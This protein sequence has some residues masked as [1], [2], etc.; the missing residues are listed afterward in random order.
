MTITLEVPSELEG[1]LQRAARVQ[2][3]DI[4]TYLL[5]SA[6]HQLRPDVLSEAESILFLRLQSLFPPEQSQEYRSLC[7]QS[8]SD[9]ISQ[10]DR[11]RLLS[12]IEQRDIKNAERLEI[13]AELA[14]LRAVPVHEMMAQLGIRPD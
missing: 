4:E 14:K 3:V 13:V 6:R 8:D 11:E 7:H 5:N 2:G 1:P 9:V 10:A 12:L